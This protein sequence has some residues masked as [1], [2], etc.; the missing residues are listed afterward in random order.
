MRFSSVATSLL[1][2]S[3]TLA[4]TPT[5]AQTERREA[6]PAQSLACLVKPERAPRYPVK[7]KLDRAFGGMRVKLS[8]TRPDA[9]PQVEVLFNSAREDMQDEAMDYLRRYRLPC[10]TPADGTVTAVQ[11]FSFSNTDRDATPLPAERAPGEAPFCLVMPRQDMRPW[12]TFGNE[13]EHLVVAATF[14]GNGQQPPEVKVIHSTGS[15]R[16]EDAVRERLAEYRMPCRTGAEPPQGFQQQFSYVPPGHRR[17]GFK[18]EAFG[19]VE[20]LRMTRHPQA[21]R[22]AFDFGTMA[23]P[24]KVKYTLYGGAVPNEAV[25]QGRRGPPDLNKLPFLTWLA[26]LELGFKNES[27]ANDL[28]GSVL[29][30][31]VPCGTLN[32][33]NSD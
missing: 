26:G 15:K 2:A 33:G 3:V 7:H 17:Y 10:L 8:F 31:D 18:R 12:N 11:E 1:V 30:I 5:S 19:L 9:A 13:I 27:Q 16:M 21:L 22:A 4:A 25:E 23:C 29:Q 6:S 32:L 20:F 24:F 28:F 14:S